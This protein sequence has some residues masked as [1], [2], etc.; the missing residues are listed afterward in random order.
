LSA[1]ASTV[2]GNLLVL[3]SKSNLYTPLS[4]SCACLGC[5]LGRNDSTQGRPVIFQAASNKIVSM[6]G[7]LAPGSIWVEQGIRGCTSYNRKT[8][9]SFGLIANRHRHMYHSF[10][11]DYDLFHSNPG[12]TRGCFFTFLHLPRAPESSGDRIRRLS[13]VKEVIMLC[14]QVQLATLIRAV[15]DFRQLGRQL[16]RIIL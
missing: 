15:A 7:T 16:R 1:L 4:W 3:G 13:R 12:H 11:F 10:P 6:S 8:W 14:Y 9:F 2:S 5:Q